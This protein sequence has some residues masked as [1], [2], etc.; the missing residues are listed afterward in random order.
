MNNRWLPILQTSAAVAI[1]LAAGAVAYLAFSSSR[2]A[3]TT[4]QTEGAGETVPA[5]PETGSSIPDA[6]LEPPGGEA[7]IET[8][9]P[10]EDKPDGEM[11]AV[12]ADDVDDA[13][14][15]VLATE[16]PDLAA[17][18]VAF[19]PAGEAR[20]NMRSGLLDIWVARAPADAVAWIESLPTG[21]FRSHALEDLGA[22]WG[23]S[24][25][26]T[27]AAWIESKLEAGEL[28]TGASAFA[29]AWA[30]TD[31]QAA[32]EWVGRLQEA[33]TSAR[34][35]GAVAFELAQDHPDQASAWVASLPDGPARQSA[36]N[37]LVSAWAQKDPAGA[38]QWLDS[39]SI[40]SGAAFPLVTYLPAI[41]AYAGKDPAAAARWADT[42]PEGPLRRAAVLAINENPARAR[43]V[44][45]EE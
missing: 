42:L 34:A 24:D 26:K 44:Q 30:E 20:D 41:L 9:P 40:E 19:L 2:P 22:S 38:L 45:P 10:D 37:N 13:R 29:A 21:K 12:F 28:E 1:V 5:P 33:S 3:R 31:P 23:A 11:E 32:A 17:Q 7:P 6:E 8:A 4:A 27:G 16:R 36:A 14:F 18:L 25:P 15:E 43:P 39:A 35:A